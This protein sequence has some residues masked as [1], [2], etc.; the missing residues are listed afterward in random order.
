MTSIGVF[1]PEQARMLWQDYLARQQLPPQ[2][3]QHFPQRRPVDD[4]AQH[5]VLVKNTTEEEIPQFACMRVTGVSLVGDRTVIEVEKPS[6]TDGEFLFNCEYAIPVE[7]TEAD[8][9]QSGVGWAYRYGI[10][11]AIR[12]EPEDPDYPPDI[13]PNSLWGPI[14]DSWAIA[15]DGT[16]FTVFGRDDRNENGL[17]GRF[18]GGGAI[19]G[20]AIVIPTGEPVPGIGAICDAVLAEVFTSSC[21]SGVAAGDIIQIWDLCRNWLNLPVELMTETSFYVQKV[22]VHEDEYNRPPALEG[23]CRWVVTGMCCVESQIYEY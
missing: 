2:Q 8:P 1:T 12:E 10:V 13:E 11:R 5:R 4:V 15:P 19:G 6:S 20:F 16:L 22:K 21:G 23:D 17:I 18:A 7:D 3:T 9:P 14:V